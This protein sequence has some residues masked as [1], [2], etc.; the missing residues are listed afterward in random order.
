MEHSLHSNVTSLNE[1]LKGMT[2][3]ER[4]RWAINTYGSGAVLLSSMQKSA[5]V[6]MHLFYKMKLDNAILFVDTGFHFRET[7]LLRDEIML[8]YKLN[9]ITLYPEQT[10]EQ[11]EKC[12]GKK[13]YQDPDGQKKCCLM[14]K[15]EP[16]VCYMKN[17][18]LKIAMIGLRRCEGGQRSKLEPLLRDPRIDGYALHPIFDWSEAQ[19]ESY[20]QENEV[21]VHPLHA[22]N[23]PSIGCECCTTPV[24]PGEDS[25]AGRWRHLNKLGSINSKYC[26]I[27]F[28]D[29]S[30]I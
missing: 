23:Y 30:G 24:K 3:M 10:P 17:N 27:N 9:I 28:S 2:A 22:K 29:G 5:S 16:Y 20:L 13:L 26:N 25:R 15:A 4:I 21:P 14:R 18:T 12:F 7:L 8:R 6:I 19:I 11:Q 1:M